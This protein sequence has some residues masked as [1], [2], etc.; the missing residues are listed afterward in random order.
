MPVVSRYRKV[1]DEW[2]PGPA[3]LDR[4]LRDRWK[5]VAEPI[6][7][8]WGFSL[9]GD[10]GLAESLEASREAGTSIRRAQQT[11][12]GLDI[13]ANVGLLPHISANFCGV[14]I[15]AVEP[16][17]VNSVL[18]FMNIER[19]PAD[20]QVLPVTIGGHPGIAEL[21][22]SGQGAS[23]NPGWGEIYISHPCSGLDTGPN[24]SRIVLRELSC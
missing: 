21:Y 15:V 9:V 6:Q 10:L 3:T 14:P 5:P 2:A 18:L 8:P 12:D 19:N 1:V 7:T 22:G 24:S 13:G 17:S 11:E 20:I 23:L 16:S 4:S